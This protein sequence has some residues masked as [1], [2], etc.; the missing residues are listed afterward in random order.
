MHRLFSP[1]FAAV[2]GVAV[3]VSAAVAAAPPPPSERDRV[4]AQDY[5]DLKP[6]PQVRF[7]TLPNGMRYALMHNATPPGQASVRFRIGAGSLQ[8]TDAQQGL[9]HYLEHM[10]FN[11]STNVPRGEMV[12][13]LE[14]NGLAFGADTNASTDWTETVYRLDLP[15]TSEPVVD[16]ALMLMREVASE[17]TISQQAVDQ[18]RGIVLSEERS[19][20]SPNYRVFKQRIDYVLKDQLAP[21]RL[22]IGQ[23]E[24]LKTAGRDR[25]VSFY[26]SFYRPERA[27]LIMVGDFDPAAM[28]AKIRARFS[29]WTAKTAKPPEAD[30]GRLAPR[31][32]EVK[33]VVEPG[34]SLIAQ[35]NWVE[36]FDATPDSAARRS[37]DLVERLALQV[38]NRRLDRLARSDDPPFVSAGASRNDEIRSATVTT[39]S[40]N[41]DPAKWREALVA[42]EEARRRLV[43]FG[44][45]PDEIAREVTEYRTVLQ[46]AVAAAA[47]RRTPALANLLLNSVDE[48][49]VIT[50]PAQN[51]ETFEAA[52]KGLTPADIDAALKR[53]FAGQGP[54]LFVA[55]PAPIPGGEPALAA[56]LHEAQNATL[57]ASA[58]QA[59]RTWS[60]T[61]FGAPGAVAETRVV[62]DLDTHFVRF[63]NGV[64]LTVKQTKFRDDQVMVSVRFGNGMLDLPKDKT[65][66]FGIG[67]A[68]V[69][70]GLKD[71]TAQDIEAL[72][73]SRVYGADLNVG[74]EAFSLNGTTRP[75]DLDVQ[76]QVLAAYMTAPGW[77]RQGFQRMRTYGLNLHRQLAATP[78]GVLQRD[79]SELLHSGDRRWRLP[80]LAEIEAGR[81]EDVRQ[82]LER[83]LA[84]GPIEV[85]IVGDVPVEQVVKAVGATFGAFPLRDGYPAPSAA[86]RDVRF[87]APGAVERTH[88][89]RPDQAVAFLAWP[90]L[91]FFAD[92]KKARDIRMLQ[93]I[94]RLRLID[95]IRVAQAATYSPSAGLESSI[96]FPGYG[97]VSASVEMPPAGIPRFFAD[98]SRIAAG[99]REKEVGADELERARKPR[100]ET[101][102]RSMQTNEFWLGQ[103]AGAQADPRR[104]DAIRTAVSDLRRVTPA[105]IRKAAQDYFLD[106]KAWRL[107]VEAQSP[108][109]GAT[110]Q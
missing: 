98:V 102:E 47:T 23:V 97:Y 27:T 18:E 85:V 17:L 68:F 8:E 40:I 38:L 78:Q 99:L 13:I 63:A 10:A 49:D 104:L 32:P 103:L 88:T 25:L 48:G 24:V 19:R 73:A 31:G 59:E 90:T 82:V 45:R 74:E 83:P 105:D 56:A 2:V 52:V 12:R 92:P 64:R 108:A 33:M 75:E 1:V 36:P 62:R 77:R 65:L 3:L 93:L 87:P 11:G 60:Y 41:A 95:E 86:A 16:T 50:S 43:Q 30:L 21:R 110:A 20:D 67:A 91:D 39:L 51:L 9:A 107:T 106:D 54:L 72:L 70:G 14:R 7:G 42:A 61:D 94:L 81:A 101:V 79:L 44:P 109:A 46:Q 15:N 28:E 22:P 71:L 57:T 89:G 69:E 55:A 80:T 100:I 53:V 34:G 96:V 58:A 26:R 84:N 6:D 35:L 29:D 4:W 37:R 76:L 66:P 5:S